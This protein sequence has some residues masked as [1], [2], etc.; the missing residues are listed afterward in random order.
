MEWTALNSP[1]LACLDAARTIVLVPIG[2]TEQHGRHLPVGVDSRLA[3]EVCAH[4]A[5]IVRPQSHVLVLPTLW[6]SLAEHHMSFAGTLTLDM[7]TFTDVL[8]CIVRSLQRQ[9]FGRILLVN[10]HGGNIAALK[11]IV[12][13]LSQELELPLAAVTYWM[14]AAPAFTAILEGQTNLRHACEAETSMMMAVDPE[15]IDF[16][17]VASAR[18]PAE[19][20]DE[21]SGVYRYRAISHWS[22]DGVVGTPH[23][24]TA[25]KGKRL[26]AAAAEALSIRLLDGSIWPELS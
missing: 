17:A 13:A 8:R 21:P 14:L 10:G 15:R 4:A 22:A 25:E 24:A 16:P 20:F 18:P 9:G 19:G 23:L 1:D 6:I 3:G 5:A 12:D 26:L 7:P 2:S 11:V